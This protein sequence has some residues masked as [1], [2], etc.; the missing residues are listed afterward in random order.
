MH[1]MFITVLF[2]IAKKWKQLK[3]SSTHK[4]IKRIWYT[5]NEILF[6]YEKNEIL[7][8]MMDLKSIMLNEI[9]WTKIKTRLSYLCVESKTNKQAQTQIH[10][11]DCWLLK[12]G[13]EVDEMCEGS[14]KKIHTFW[15][16]INKF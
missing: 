14:Q 15:Y 16:K 12:M 4:W 2:T 8:F 7:P 11:T 6:S 3:Y 10:R 5:Y 13:V 1:L 9:S